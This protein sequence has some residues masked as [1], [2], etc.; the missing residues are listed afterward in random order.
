MV[1]FGEIN[2]KNIFVNFK[3]NE[4]KWIWNFKVNIDWVIKI[5]FLF[6]KRIILFYLGIK[7]VLWILV[8]RF[9]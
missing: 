7:I 4:M 9:F 1:R 8:K 3:R 2:F 6:V 5:C